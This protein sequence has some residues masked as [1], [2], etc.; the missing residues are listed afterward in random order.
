MMGVDQPLSHMLG[1]V[2][3]QPL[4]PVGHPAGK[5]LL[6]EAAISGFEEAKIS[7]C[8]LGGWGKGCESFGKSD[9]FHV[10][11]SGLEMFGMF[12]GNEIY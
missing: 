4:P 12:R 10:K 7:V 6:T 11:D 5:D 1:S 9:M 8:G 3:F 2:V